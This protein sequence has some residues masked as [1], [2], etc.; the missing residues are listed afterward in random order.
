[1]MINTDTLVAMT[2]AN[3]NF[4]KVTHVVDENGM[5]VILKNNKPRYVVVDFDEYEIINEIRAARTLKVEQV[6]DQLIEENMEAFM[7]LAK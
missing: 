7:E 1:M 4:S 3:Q 5:A 6:A 2:D